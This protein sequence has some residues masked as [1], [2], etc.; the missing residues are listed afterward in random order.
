MFVH[1]CLLKCH[2]V[3][4]APLQS[5]VAAVA[6]ADANGFRHFID[7]DLPVADLSGARSA[8]QAWSTSS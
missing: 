2:Q 3:E 8:A 7:K 6:V 5:Q 1:H 4:N